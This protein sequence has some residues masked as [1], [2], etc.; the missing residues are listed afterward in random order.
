M[1]DEL[2]ALTRLTFEELGRATG[3]IGDVHRAI[4]D[5]AFGAVGPQA[6]PSRARTTRSR[7]AST[8]ACAAR[9]AR[10]GGAAARAVPAARP[11]SMTPR[12]ARALAVLNGLLGDVLERE[13]SELQEPMAVRVGGQV[14]EPAR[15]RAPR[16]R[17][18]R[19]ARSSSSTG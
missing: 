12:G 15:G 19:R 5:R 7:A 11:L 6:R 14:V 4:A 16:S 1:A 10:S 13:G 2:R 9:R 17:P 18:R 8:P 3:G